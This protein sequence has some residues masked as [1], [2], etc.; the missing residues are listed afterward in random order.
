[1][2]P[3]PHPG[4]ISVRQKGGL[5]GLHAYIHTYTYI[6]T[7]IRTYTHIHTYIHTHTHTPRRLCRPHSWSQSRPIF[8]QKRPIFSQKN[9]NYTWQKWPVDIH[10]SKETY[11][12]ETYIYG[13][14][15]LLQWTSQKRPISSQKRPISKETY[16]KRPIKRDLLLHVNISKETYLKETC[17]RAKKSGLSKT[18]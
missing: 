4:L 13:L 15:L 14:H 12:K 11:L 3:L 6:H 16:Q 2:T 17:L 5:P 9:P 1:M 7:Y 8:S 10:I 18:S